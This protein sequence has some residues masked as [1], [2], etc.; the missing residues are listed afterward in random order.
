MPN[1]QAQQNVCPSCEL[2]GSTGFVVEYDLFR[3]LDFGPLGLPESCNRIGECCNCGHLYR[4]HTDRE[5]EFIDRLYKSGEYTAHREDH[6]VQHDDRLLQAATAQAEL[7]LPHLE[8]SRGLA[9]LD[10]GCFD[11][12]LL[13]ALKETG[14][15]QRLVGFD[16]EQRP[17]FFEKCAGE[18][19]TGS[20]DNV[21]GKFD[22]VILSQSLMYI[23]DLPALFRKT[24]SLLELGGRLFIHVPD[25]LQKPS[26]L[27]LGDQYHYFTKG[28]LETLLQ[29][30]GYDPVFLPD[31]PFPRDLLM[32]S[33][34]TDEE[35][36]YSQPK[37]VL[38]G[39]I[40]S[41]DATRNRLREMAST[42]GEYTVLGTTMEASFVHSLLPGKVTAF[43]DEDPHKVGN[44]FHGK[45]VFHPSG[46]SPRQHCILPLSS[47][48][49]HVLTRF[50][51]EYKGHFHLLE[52]EIQTSA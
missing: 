49:V 7:L 48:A 5:R 19:V 36:H 35:K 33:K 13:G 44:T 3:H 38:P 41:M 37:M 30:F 52:A 11:G 50:E 21:R 23:K 26:M 18:F 2:G 27:L 14:C 20:L 8:K 24:N 42:L 12:S 4:I 31:T 15:S 10:I 17:C 16:V 34:K 29:Q 40:E 43:V 32:I 51:A 45:P 28:K 1:I 22:L 9:I 46:L 47:R 25:I 39:L 6:V